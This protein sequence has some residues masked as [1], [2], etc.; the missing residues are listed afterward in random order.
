MQAEQKEDVGVIVILH[1]LNRIDTRH[2][3][4]LKKVG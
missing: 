3:V 4:A 2:I 1:D